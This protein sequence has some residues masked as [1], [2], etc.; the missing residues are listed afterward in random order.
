MRNLQ[1]KRSMVVFKQINR[2]SL[3]LIALNSLFLFGYVLFPLTVRSSISLQY[4]LAFMYRINLPLFGNLDNPSQF[5]LHNSY[6]LKIT[7][8]LCENIG[9]WHI[10]PHNSTLANTDP[11]HPRFGRYGPVILYSHGNAGSRA[12]YH[13]LDS[14]QFM[15]RKGYEVVAFDYRGYADSPGSVSEVG[16]VNDT[17]SVYKFVLEHLEPGATVY[18]WGHSL[19]SAIVI[20][21]MHRLL[22]E[23]PKVQV[24]DGVILECPFLNFYEAAYHYPLFWVY[25]IIPPYSDWLMRGRMIEF[26]SDNKIPHL[27]AEL[28]IL[29]VHAQSDFVIPHWQG[30]ALYRVANLSGDMQLGV[31]KCLRFGSLPNTGH[32]GCASSVELDGH[33]DEFVLNCT[34][35]I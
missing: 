4:E 1:L 31:P 19:G 7:H 25:R 17:L 13:R 27:A 8:D 28:P 22:I 35:S 15:A 23:Q 14:Y 32:N 18:L 29:I 33:L 9:A 12:L 20:Q 16:V 24:P 34:K 10:L 30:E 11:A 2:S 3:L 5:G 21:A 26:D 6:S